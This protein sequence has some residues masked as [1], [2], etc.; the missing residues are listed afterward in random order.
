MLQNKYVL[1]LYSKDQTNDA[2][3]PEEVIFFSSELPLASLQVFLTDIFNDSADIPFKNFP[4]DSTLY[5][6]ERS[7]LHTLDDYFERR[8]Y[9]L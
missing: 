3:V 8:A 9:T 2:E 7:E 1:L 5:S 6:K 4:I